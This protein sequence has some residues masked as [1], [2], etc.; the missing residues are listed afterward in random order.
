MIELDDKNLRLLSYLGSRGS[1]GKALLDMAE[2]KHFYAVSA[3]LAFGSGISSFRDKYPERYIDVGIAEQ[4]MVAVAAGL[5]T[6]DVPVIAASWG[7]FASYRCA[8][9]IRCYLGL[10]N[11]NVKIIGAGSGFSEARFGGSHFGIGDMAMVRSIPGI[12]VIVPCDGLEV[13]AAVEAAL[14]NDRPTYIR[15][16]GGDRLP[17]INRDP[18]YRFEVGKANMLRDGR[19]VLVVGCG[20]LLSECVKAAELLDGQG[21]SVKVLDMH[22]IKP[23]DTEALLSSLSCRLIVTVEEHNVIG[24]LGSAVAEALSGVKDRPVQ[25]RLGVDDF[26]PGAGDY[27]NLLECCGLTAEQIAGRIQEELGRQ[28]EYHRL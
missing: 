16:T 9:Q 7:A 2:K 23:L 11:S 18:A 4:D 22:T 28:G 13:Y 20:G 10:M 8:D 17:I 14:S 6:R 25:L 24:G 21:I 5:A 1:L 19:D 12:D 3:D 15:M 26:V 27:G